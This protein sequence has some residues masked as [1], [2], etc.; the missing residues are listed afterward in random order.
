[1]LDGAHTIRS[2]VDMLHPKMPSASWEAIKAEVVNLIGTLSKK[3][4]I[5]INWDPLYKLQKSQELN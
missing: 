5:I 4:S 3:K 2:I 1:M